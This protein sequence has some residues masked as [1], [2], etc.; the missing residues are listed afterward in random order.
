MLLL[1]CTAIRVRV[2]SVGGS[3][4]IQTS[5]PHCTQH[6]R[7][8]MYASPQSSITRA[9][10][11]ATS[12]L[13]INKARATGAQRRTAFMPSILHS[14][15]PYEIR[16]TVVMCAVVHTL[17]ICVRTSKKK[18]TRAPKISAASI[19]RRLTSWAAGFTHEFSSK[20]QAKNGV[21]RK[22]MVVP[23]SSHNAAKHKHASHIRI[24]HANNHSDVLTRSRRRTATGAINLFH[25]Q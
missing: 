16:L 7:L 15:L 5:R 2:G 23:T 22:Q 12:Q 25:S 24:T 19:K 11:C 14:T 20:H 17:W 10:I 13:Q 9:C 18:D 3:L 4:F 1:Y 8:E 6:P 21:A